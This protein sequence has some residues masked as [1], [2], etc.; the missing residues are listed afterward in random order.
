[1]AH[2]LPAAEPVPD[3]DLRQRQ[4]RAARAGLAAASAERPGAPVQDALERAGLWDEVKDDLDR[5]ALG[6]SGGQQQR[7]CIA[8]T[9]AAQP[10]VLLIDEPCSA[11]DPRST[12]IIEELI[13]Q[14]RES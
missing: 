1:M 3:V 2:G 8:R 11:L 9:L 10:E 4:L 13:L 5:S 7:L 12:A 6:L 14:L